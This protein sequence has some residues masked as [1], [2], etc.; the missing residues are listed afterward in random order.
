VGTTSSTTAGAAARPKILPTESAAAV[1]GTRAFSGG[2]ARHRFPGVGRPVD[3]E[4]DRKNS[5]SDVSCENLST[6]CNQNGGDHI[7]TISMSL[8]LPVGFAPL[9]ADWTF[10][11]CLGADAGGAPWESRAK[12][13][14]KPRH[15]HAAC[16]PKVS[17]ASKV[18]V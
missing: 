13:L 12:T 3:V 7:T 5:R 4:R 18:G 9:S 8:V 10:F 17:A 1:L 15:D 16:A 2:K 6:F 11:A 14:G